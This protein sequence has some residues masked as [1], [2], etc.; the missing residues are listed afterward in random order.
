MAKV[1]LRVDASVATK[2]GN[3]SPSLLIHA[4]LNDFLS[5][6]TY[7][8]STYVGQAKHGSLSFSC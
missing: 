4:R 7:L 3:A 5:T 2:G 8:P 6:I 1:R